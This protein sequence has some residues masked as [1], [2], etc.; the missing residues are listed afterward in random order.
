MLLPIW[1]HR[2]TP[3]DILFIATVNCKLKVATYSFKQ[4]TACRFLFNIDLFDYFLF[5]E[6]INMKFG[7][8]MLQVLEA[9]K[10]NK[11]GNFLAVSRATCQ[12]Q[13]GRIFTLFPEYSRFSS[14]KASNFLHT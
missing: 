9:S 1:A 5:V 10:T 12:F 14:V 2:D 13:S 8:N 3:L 4:N 7:F 11:F 6:C